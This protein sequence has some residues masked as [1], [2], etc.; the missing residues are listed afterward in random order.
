MLVKFDCCQN[1]L[2]SHFFA[3]MSNHPFVA[4]FCSVNLMNEILKLMYILHSFMV[5][6]KK[7]CKLGTICLLVNTNLSRAKVTVID[8]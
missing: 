8:Y 6:K 7:R 3:E 5:P 1:I 4:S 2:F